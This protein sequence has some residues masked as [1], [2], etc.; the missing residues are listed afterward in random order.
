MD[1]NRSHSKLPHGRQTGVR[2]GK[3]LK[4]IV[5]RGGTRAK[6]KVPGSGTKRFPEKFLH[7]VLGLVRIT[8][9]RRTF[10]WATS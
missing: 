1:S 2:P 4:M 9:R 8:A 6:H 7:D 5:W 10:P 3:L